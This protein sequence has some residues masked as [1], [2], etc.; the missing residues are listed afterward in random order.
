M[1]YYQIDSCP[2]IK[3]QKWYRIYSNN[4]IVQT[5]KK[6]VQFYKAW[7]LSGEVIY[8]EVPAGKDIIVQVKFAE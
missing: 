8:D 5:D 6:Y 1:Q 3:L 2:Y 4:G 7:H